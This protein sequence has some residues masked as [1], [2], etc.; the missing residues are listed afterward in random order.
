MKYFFL[1]LSFSFNLI[2][3]I[4]IILIGI[5][6]HKE[7]LLFLFLAFNIFILYYLIR[8]FT[9]ANKN[10][11]EPK[12]LESQYQRGL[13]FCYFLVLL[14]SG[15]FLIDGLI[16]SIIELEIVKSDR[17]YHDPMLFLDVGFIL[18]PSFG[19]FLIVYSL[20]IFYFVIKTRKM[21]YTKIK[22]N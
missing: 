21:I 13:K 8:A 4:G 7:D 5:M 17:L 1:K 6:S 9:L 11:F 22:L 14:I 16:I 18:M 19:I 3:S 2:F 12:Q 20:S 10:S 15:I